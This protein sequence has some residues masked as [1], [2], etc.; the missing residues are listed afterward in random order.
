MSV[1]LRRKM[2]KLGG[3]VSKTHGVGITSN[4]NYNKGGKVDPRPPGVM[5][6]PDGQMR[7]AHNP[8]LSGLVGP[9]M[10]ILRSG[11]GL[12]SKGLGGR[13]KFL[14]NFSSKGPGVTSFVRGDPTIKRM[15]GK[16]GTSRDIITR[17]PSTTRAAQAARAAQLA[18]APTGIAGTAAGLGTAAA[19]RAG[20]INPIEPDD[21][22]F[23]KFGK[24]TAQSLADFN[25]ANAL[26]M[27]IQKGMGVICSKTNNKVCNK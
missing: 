9:G 11:A 1:T 13:L 18:L 14:K 10:A 15:V 17:A 22:P 16:S 25:L 8:L 26:S 24:F 19:Q 7:E 20:F 5:R 21:S 3:E 6:G 12:L 23:T 2:F 4:L 27:G